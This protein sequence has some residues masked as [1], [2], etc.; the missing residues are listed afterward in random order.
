[1]EITPCGHCGT[2]LGEKAVE[3]APYPERPFGTAEEQVLRDYRAKQLDALATPRQM[4]RFL[5]GLSSPATTRTKLNREAGFGVL[6]D[7]PF[8]RV[9]EWVESQ[10]KN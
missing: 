10:T 6:A 1:M 2:C 5:C 4:T 7:V 8:K 9:L 3:L